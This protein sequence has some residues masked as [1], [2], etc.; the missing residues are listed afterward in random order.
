MKQLIRY[1]SLLVICTALIFLG[2]CTGGGGPNVRYSV[3][4]GYGGGYYGRSPYGYGR[5]DI[6]VVP[7]D[8]PVAMPMSE[9]DFGMP[10]AGFDDFGGFDDF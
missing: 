4:M 7:D 2:A 3:G 1:S 8:R 5:P 6:I 9:P 10:E